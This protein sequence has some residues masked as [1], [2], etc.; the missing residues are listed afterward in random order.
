MARIE[1]C[2]HLISDPLV[3]GAG[4]FASIHPQVGVAYIVF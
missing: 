3:E 4:R 2:G 1:C